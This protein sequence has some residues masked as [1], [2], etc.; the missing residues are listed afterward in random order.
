MLHKKLIWITVCLMLVLAPACFAVDDA[1]YTPSWYQAWDGTQKNILTTFWDNINPFYT[2]VEDADPY[3]NADVYGWYEGTFFGLSNWEREICLM[4]L[5]TEVAN[6]RSSAT[7]EDEVEI[8][9]TTLT[10]AAKKTSL[11]NTTLYEVSWY[12]RP[13][14]AS[15]QYRVFLNNGI[16]KEY[17][18]GSASSFASAPLSGQSGYVPKYINANFTEVTLEYKIGSESK[19]YTSRV[20]LK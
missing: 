18:A 17:F 7:S 3:D 12:I 19:N 14:G 13:D 6:V 16:S 8:Y 5:T 20:V 9:T 15:A 2:P 10:V 11:Y 1:I 4:D